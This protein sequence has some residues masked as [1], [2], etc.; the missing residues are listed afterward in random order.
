M[1]LK[2]GAKDLISSMFLTVAIAMIFT[3][4]IG[5]LAVIIDGAITSR[6]IGVQAY[7]AVSLVS[8]IISTILLFS[9]FISTGSQLIISRFVGTGD[10]DEAISVFTFSL[11]CAA[12]I[13]AAFLLA[14]WLI[15]KTLCTI[16]GVSVNKY[17]ELMPSMINYIHGYMFGIPA[18]V[19]IGI[20]GPIIVMDGG[21]KLFSV[22]SAIFLVSDIGADLLN[23]LVFKGGTFGMGM[24]TTISY[25]IQFVVL[26]QHFFRKTGYFKLSK[27]LGFKKA[28]E[29]FKA[30]S[31][32]FIRKLF[33]IIR[34][35]ITNHINI[36]VAV[37][38]AA[39]A[40]R[41]L[42]N[43]LNLL[44]FC[45]GLG[46]GRALLSMTGFYHSSD[47]RQGLKRLFSYSMKVSLLISASVG[48]VL[49]FVAPLI[50]RIYTSDEEVIALSVFSIRCMAI[51]L[52]MD[53]LAVSYQSYLQ[54]IKNRK[55]VNIISFVER[56]I[57]P[58]LTA[59]FMGRLF[60]SK[61]VMASLAVGK[62]ILVIVMFVMIWIHNRHFPKHIEDYMYLP[63]DFGGAEE[64]NLYAMITSMDDVVKE[65]DSA[66]QFCLS[67]GVSTKNALYCALFIEEMAG[68]IV[69]HAKS[70][71]KK[72]VSADFRLYISGNN[73]SITLRDYSLTFDPKEYL[74]IN[75]DA[76]KAIGIKMVT[77]LASDVRYFNAFNSNNVIILL[78]N[79]D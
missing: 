8:P 14:C 24:A 3:Q 5:I 20:V 75:N 56:L 45:I 43:D 6:A 65:K 35:L 37:S 79:K 19:C 59:F 25:W 9:T 1:P 41:G 27:D 7:S 61:G 66:E 52:P 22:S 48:V 44:M 57:I 77:S 16:C 40:A 62:V 46:I 58:I 72:P 18:V 50:S 63:A 31:P 70:K 21:K 2:K 32:A 68:N 34:D 29:V 4:I 11:I 17:P 39:I 71:S 36:A 42:Q 67:H 33:T 78:E 60:G 55:M 54:G 12:V 23:V 26:I 30:G 76:E 69:Q 64:D 73:I 38:A 15:P 53:S 13:S 10:K 49:L 28:T 51:G 74:R 47:D